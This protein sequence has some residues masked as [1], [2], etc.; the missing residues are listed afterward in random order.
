MF[1]AALRRPGL[2]RTVLLVVLVFAGTLPAAAASGGLAGRSP[3]PSA[4]TSTSGPVIYWAPLPTIR[5]VHRFD[6]PATRYGPGHLGVD[7]ATSPGATVRVAGAG[8]V[9]FA[10]SVAGRGVVV[11]QHPDGIRTEYEPVRPARGVAAGTALARGAPLG[12]V[13]GAHR[14]CPPGRCLHWGA[15]RGDTYLDPLS[16]LVALSP[17]RL[18]PWGAPHRY[19]R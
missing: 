19:P 12:V 18:L 8:V 14:G 15:R 1:R 6:P 17:V 7:L 4:S 3:A 16:L 9:R 10:G 2:R 11:V 13:D 5:V